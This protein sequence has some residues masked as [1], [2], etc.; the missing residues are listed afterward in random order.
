MKIDILYRHPADLAAE[1]M[2]GRLHGYA[3]TSTQANRTVERMTRTRAGLVYI[4]T[5]LLPSL[6]KEKGQELYCWLDKVLT[7]VDVT[8]IDAQG[9]I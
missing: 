4:M 3:A 7:L 5:E 6:D 2:L 9:D 1:T 8:R